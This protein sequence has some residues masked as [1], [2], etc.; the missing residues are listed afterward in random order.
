LSRLV[1][2]NKTVLPESISS[3]EKGIFENTKND[4]KAGQYLAVFFKDDAKAFYHQQSGTEVRMS[5]RQLS[6]TLKERY[7]GA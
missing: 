1:I 5:Y 2:I 7:K 3:Q 4:E 6:Q